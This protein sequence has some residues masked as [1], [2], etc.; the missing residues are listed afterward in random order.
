[1]KTPVRH[2]ASGIATSLFADRRFDPRL[3]LDFAASQGV[4]CVQLYLSGDLE[5]DPSLVDEL[6]SCASSLGLSILC[7][8]S[9]DLG[10]SFADPGHLA[11]LARFFPSGSR[12]LAVA[13]FD[14][15]VPLAD[16]LDA[17][18][19]CA[20]SGLELCLENYYRSETAEELRL[21]IAT[22]AHLCN[23]AR[24]EGL[25]LIP[26]LDLPRLYIDR[27]ARLADPAGACRLLLDLLSPDD[28]A[29]SGRRECILHLIDFSSPL[30]RREDW[31]PLG[32]GLMNWSAIFSALGTRGFSV[33]SAVLEYE[34]SA[35][36]Q[37]SLDALDSL[38][39]SML[40]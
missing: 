38:L 32:S 4:P 25:P 18:R 1:V 27:L 5:Q 30:Q 12:R 11:A 21:N 23:L 16:M 19:A 22:Y 31:V 37:A 34:D 35:C 20:Q 33:L 17:V 40:P 26:V 15:R 24:E 3:A 39:R 36:A 13:H 14:E 29:S 9:R 7:H 10:P 2:P 6:R 8:S 28:A